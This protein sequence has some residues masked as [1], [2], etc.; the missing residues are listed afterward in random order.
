MDT[1]D[2]THIILTDEMRRGFVEP[3]FQVVRHLDPERNR[4]SRSKAKSNATRP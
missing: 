1:T 4:R 3:L 2:H